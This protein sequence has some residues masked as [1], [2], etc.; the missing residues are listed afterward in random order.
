MPLSPRA[1]PVFSSM[2][3]DIKS[4]FDKLNKELGAKMT[5][6]YL[7]AMHQHGTEETT[8]FGNVICDRITTAPSIICR[9]SPKSSDWQAIIETDNGFASR[10]DIIRSGPDT[11]R[12][13]T[14]V[15]IRPQWTESRRYPQIILD[16]SYGV[17][18]EDT[19]ARQDIFSN[20]DD[21]SK[22]NAKQ[23][24]RDALPFV[25]RCNALRV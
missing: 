17:L 24:M 19:Q 11:F 3:S 5:L 25:G 8:G 21:A 7:D 1:S 12:G 16:F 18:S 13:S 4:C 22:R 9:I 6:P 15:A 20:L 23:L 14:T 2:Q 10:L